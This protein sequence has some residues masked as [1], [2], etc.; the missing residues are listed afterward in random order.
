VD[1]ARQKKKGEEG[2]TKLMILA[3]QKFGQKLTEK[4]LR[5]VWWV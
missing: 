1:P 3:T 5:Y 4:K 2:Q